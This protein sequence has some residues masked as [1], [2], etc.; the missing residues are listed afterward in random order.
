MVQEVPG[1]CTRV[2][3]HGTTAVFVLLSAI[4]GLREGRRRGRI[5]SSIGSV[6]VVLLVKLKVQSKTIGVVVHRRCGRGI[7]R[8]GG[9]V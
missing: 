3:G 9:N 2:R 8:K 4:D 7:R 5:H 1:I 6:K